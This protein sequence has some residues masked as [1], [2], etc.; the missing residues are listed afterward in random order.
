MYFQFLY[1]GFISS[2]CLT[3][4]LDLQSRGW[5]ASLVLLDAVFYSSYVSSGDDRYGANDWMSTKPWVSPPSRSLA[6]KHT[7]KNGGNTSVKNQPRASFCSFTAIRV[8]LTRFARFEPLPQTLTSSVSGQTSLQSPLEII[9][10]KNQHR[11][12]H[13]HAAQHKSSS[14]DYE[15]LKLFSNIFQDTCVLLKEA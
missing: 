12:A 2:V 1:N 14:A 9:V 15:L 5:C 13:T 11:L 8:D 4:A 3:W 10:T 7:Q 6:L